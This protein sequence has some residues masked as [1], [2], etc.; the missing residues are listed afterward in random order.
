MAGV[1]RYTGMPGLFGSAGGGPGAEQLSAAV[2]RRSFHG[3]DRPSEAPPVGVVHHGERD[4]SGHVVVDEGDV[5]GIIYGTI[6]NQ[7]IDVT[8]ALIRLLLDD[9]DSTLPRLN[10]PFAL[11]CLDRTRDRIVIATDKVSTRALYFTTEAPFTFASEIEPVLE[12]VDEPTIDTQAVSDLLLMAHVWGNK[13]L[14]TEVKRLRPASYVLYE[15]GEWEENRYW[16]FSFDGVAGD[17]YVADVAQAYRDAV[18]DVMTTS[19]GTHGLW[20]SGGLDSRMMVA[21]MHRASRD[22]RTYTY[23][24][25]LETSFGPFLDDID[26]AQTISKTLDVPHEVLTFSPEVL[27]D[28]L[29][30]LVQLTDGLVGWNT[31]LNLSAVFDVDP[32]DVGVMYEGSGS[33]IICGEHVWSTRL[34]G[35]SHPADALYDMHA[36]CDGGLVKST[37]TADIEPKDTFIDEVRAGPYTDRDSQILGAAHMNYTPRKHF[38][39]NKVARANVGTREQLPNGRLLD[40]AGRLPKEMRTEPMPFTG[41][42]VPHVPS[43]MKLALMR[44]LDGDLLD[45]P[46]EGTQL[47]PSYPYALHGVGFVAKN[48]VQRGLSSTTL[49][50]WYRENDT[51]RHRLDELL[52]SAAEREVFDADVLSRIRREHLRGEADWMEF[53]SH[54][55]TAELFIQRVFDR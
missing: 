47:P 29:P 26:L 36:R 23:K 17:D 53:I 19:S 45:I 44:E 27:V 4:P 24:R 11:V 3:E 48:V 12:A 6:S 42:R 28:R 2:Y 21:A 51:F 39:S 32:D 18:S 55:T 25:P 43:P 46:Y 7:E 49:D 9:P 22:L 52:Q 5:A 20:L 50:E 31:L 38:M 1:S 15:D 33:A 41:G 16:K 13:T 14:A 54:V 8:P 30:E 10:G 35:S 34:G 37:V 40:L